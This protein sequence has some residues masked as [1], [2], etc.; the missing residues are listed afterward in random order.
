MS[1]EVGNTEFVSQ[2]DNIE[3]IF[4]NHD[5]VPFVIIPDARLPE[6]F[7]IM[8]VDPVKD[9]LSYVRLLSSQLKEFVRIDARCLRES[10]RTEGNLSPLAGWSPSQHI[11]KCLDESERT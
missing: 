5:L 6:G 8:V 3:E 9:T 11:L 7:G 10:G 2:L 1:Q 4:E